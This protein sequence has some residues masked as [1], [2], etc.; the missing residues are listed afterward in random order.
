MERLVQLPE[1]KNT[2]DIISNVFNERLSPF[3]KL[4]RKSEDRKIEKIE[5]DSDRI[6]Y[7]S[8]EVR[9]LVAQGMDSIRSLIY[10][11][12]TDPEALVDPG[13]TR[14]NWQGHTV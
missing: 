10:T 14:R 8:L 4:R 7:K 5:L 6:Y 11:P 2:V 1:K 12:L 3:T 13:L 9:E